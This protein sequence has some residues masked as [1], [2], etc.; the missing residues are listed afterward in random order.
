MFG[1]WQAYLRPALASP[2][3]PDDA[4]RPSPM[5]LLGAARKVREV[6][7]SDFLGAANWE[8]LFVGLMLAIPLYFVVSTG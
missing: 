1:A 3:V 5:P 8:L 4:A 2:V 7:N 6:L